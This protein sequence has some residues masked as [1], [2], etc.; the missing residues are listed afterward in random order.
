[1]TTF[2]TEIRLNNPTYESKEEAIQVA[3]NNADSAW[4]EKAMSIL[5][6]LCLSQSLISS[7]DLRR[8][9]EVE[10]ETTNSQNA[11]AGLLKNA[12]KNGWLTE[13]RCSCGEECSTKESEKLSNHGRRI[14]VYSSLLI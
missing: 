13:K 5:H 1:M 11:I 4:K 12:K 6:D 7:D 8:R 14:L 9:M 3:V 10:P 2:S